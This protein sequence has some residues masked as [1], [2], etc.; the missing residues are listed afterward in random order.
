MD[1]AGTWT[2]KISPGTLIAP[3]ALVTGLLP[4]DTPL[5][6]RCRLDA[7]GIAGSFCSCLFVS[8]ALDWISSLQRNQ[9]SLEACPGLEHFCGLVG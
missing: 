2:G 7:Q 4:A 5:C 1:S 8:S 9:F 3:E 6:S